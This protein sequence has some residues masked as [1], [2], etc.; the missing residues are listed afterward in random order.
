MLTL[1]PSIS[2]RTAAAE[3]TTITLYDRAISTIVTVSLTFVSGN[4]TPIARPLRQTRAF[5]LVVD[6]L[7]KALVLA[8]S[9]TDIMVAIFAVKA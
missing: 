5:R 4:I 8:V 1:L 9:G 7:T 3:R 6:N 2:G